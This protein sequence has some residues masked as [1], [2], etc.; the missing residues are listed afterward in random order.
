[1][2]ERMSEEDW[3][4]VQRAYDHLKSGGPPI[5]VKKKKLLHQSTL[6]F[7]HSEAWT[8]FRPAER[9]STSA[10]KPPKQQAA[11]EAAELE[12]A[13]ALKDR[14]IVEALADADLS[15]IEKE[16]AK[17]RWRDQNPGRVPPWEA[18]PPPPEAAPEPTVKKK[19]G[20]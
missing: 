20:R 18:A 9:P 1:M 17:K 14:F 13:L 6:K 4:M 19:G 15:E 10:S 8:A 12:A 7:L 3:S 11:E 5:G 2:L 16:R